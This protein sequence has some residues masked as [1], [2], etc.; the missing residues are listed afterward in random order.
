MGAL[1]KSEI[2]ETQQLADGKSTRT[3]LSQR[4]LVFSLF[5]SREIGQLREQAVAGIEKRGMPSMYKLLQN[6]DW[7]IFYQNFQN[8]FKN[9]SQKCFHNLG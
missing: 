5:F 8:F 1:C 6:Q 9:C 3:P 4:H 2:L 7:L